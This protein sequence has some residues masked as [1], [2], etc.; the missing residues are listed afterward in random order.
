MRRVKKNTVVEIVFD[1]HVQGA[2]DAVRCVVFG[3]VHCCSP[4]QI[5]VK[6]WDYHAP[7]AGLDHNIE[8]F[9]I[10]QS[11]IIKLRRLG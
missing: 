6:S 7:T 2:D 10:L 3:R 9:T 11:T 8:T 5:T 1:D 4:K